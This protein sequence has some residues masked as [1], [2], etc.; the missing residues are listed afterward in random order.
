MGGPDTVAL[1]DMVKKHLDKNITRFII[2]MGKVKWINSSGLGVLM[3]AFGSVC[4]VNGLIKLVDVTKK[5]RSLLIM[6]QIITF[7]ETY[8]S[9]DSALASLN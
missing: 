3:A 8:D 4:K 5:V 9:I 2:D 6:V 1:H 7:F